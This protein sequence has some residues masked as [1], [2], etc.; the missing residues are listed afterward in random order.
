MS[1]YTLEDEVW[2]RR[3]LDLAAQGAGATNPNPLVGAVLV[4]QGAVVGEGFTQPYGDHHAEWVALN[5][6]GA[7]AQGAT[8]YV[9][10]EPCV[11]YPGKHTPPCAERLVQAGVARVVVAALDPHPRVQGRGVTL[12]QQAGVV[13]E[14]GLLEALAL[15]L[16]EVSVVYHGQQRPFVC[17]KWAMTLDGKIAAHTGD[18]KWV[19]GPDSRRRVHELRRRYA[20]ILVG[21]NT[22][23]QDDPE[24]TV[25]HVEGAD[26]WRIVLDSRGG[27]PL[28]ARLLSSDSKAPTVVATTEAMPR[29]LEQKLVQQ[30]V[31]VWRLPAD[32]GRVD[33]EALL[34]RVRS[35]Q[36]DS[37]FV[38]G[39]ADVHW[40]FVDQ[41][42]VDKVVCFVAP[43]LV[44][45]R[46]AKG[47]L[48]GEGFASM[49]GALQ[50][51]RVA[52]ETLG[53][54]VVISGYPRP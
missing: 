28:E 18:S 17:L 38:E 20:A 34:Q 45:G 42:L 29:A 41:G 15:A 24:L 53:A 12:L 50:L 21:L 47:P 48:G 13:V 22:V 23:V 26:P 6:A 39:G 51:E 7:R 25:R 33:L 4:N 9:N 40:S 1:A 14:V 8:L 30:H 37:V 32:R 35:E 36:L 11:A 19:S 16:N 5:A 44:G 49:S 3:A 2:M 43:K 52:V 27:V 46:K 31:R 54:D 10:W